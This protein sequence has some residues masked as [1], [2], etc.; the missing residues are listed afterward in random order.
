MSRNTVILAG[1]ALLVAVVALILQFALP[2]GDGADDGAAIASLRNDIDA[3][4]N[5]ATAP[6]LRVAYMNAEEAFS[7]F[8]DEVSDLRGKAEEKSAEIA[9]LQA[10]AAAGTISPDE[11]SKQLGVFQ[12]EL[13]EAQWIIDMGT[14][15]VMIASQGF[16]DIRGDLEK[17]KDQTE[18]YIE[19]MKNLVS[20]ATVGIIDS[21]DFQARYAQLSAA[22]AN[23][24][25]LLTNAASMKI[26]E[27]AQ[28]VAIEQGYD[29]VLRVK[30]VIMYRNP[31][32]LPDITDLVRQ[33]IASYL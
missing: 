22:F 9:Q 6:S 30:N 29:L 11:Y 8:L 20:L 26:V 28:Q 2:P 10:Q 1:L 16:S 19:E 17:L 33:K 14:I 4:Q 3:L 15:N 27:A 18:P 7:V 21:D 13:L 31:A 5:Q 25:Q 24:D 32:A 12:V 23:L